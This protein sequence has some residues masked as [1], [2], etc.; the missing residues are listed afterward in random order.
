ME[1]KLLN[2]FALYQVRFSRYSYTLCKIAGITAFFLVL[3]SGSASAQMVQQWNVFASTEGSTAQR[4]SDSALDADGNVYLLGSQDSPGSEYTMTLMKYD[5]KGQKV[6]HKKLENFQYS[7]RE[8]PITLKTGKDG[9]IY[10]LAVFTRTTGG[11]GMLFYKVSPDGNT[12]WIR[13]YG[14]RAGSID[15]AYDFMLS[16]DDDLYV[17]GFHSS[18]QGHDLFVLK[19]NEAGILKWEKRLDNMKGHSTYGPTLALGPDGEPYVAVRGRILSQ[20]VN[21][22]PLLLK[23]NGT[24]GQVVDTKK[25]TQPEMGGNGADPRQLY[26]NAEGMVY[27]VSQIS[28]GYRYAILLTKADADGNMIWSSTED[29]DGSESLYACGFGREPDIVWRTPLCFYHEIYQR[30][31]A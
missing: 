4:F 20:D 28:I 17:A 1:Q 19:Y 10:V 21:P 2:Y 15:R 11:Q 25:F 22:Y 30:R 5:A 3:L 27:M 13:P 6:W 14:Y 8:F 9:D 7:S 31:K 24:S 29:A 18:T 12:Q 26:I 23:L 16:E